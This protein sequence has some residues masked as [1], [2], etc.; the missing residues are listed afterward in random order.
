MAIEN[1]KD[2]DRMM[3]G[4]MVENHRTNEI[5]VLLYTWT[6]RFADGD[7]PYATCVDKNGKKY[8][9]PMDDISP[10]EE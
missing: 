4:T 9:I 7:I 3:F 8:S 10:I 5:G 6:N 1:L 2:L